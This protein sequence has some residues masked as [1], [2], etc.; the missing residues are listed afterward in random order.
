MNVTGLPTKDKTTVQELYC[1]F[2][3][4]Y[5][6]CNCKLLVSFFAKSLNKPL[7]GYCKAEYFI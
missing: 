6:P 4:I 5:I 3:K 7:K 2:P 1:L